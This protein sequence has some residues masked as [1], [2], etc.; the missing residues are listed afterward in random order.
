MSCI[1]RE[2]AL[3]NVRIVDAETDAAGI[4]F[5]C[6]EKITRIA[7]GDF[8]VRESAEGL[9]K[10]SGERA[11]IDFVDGGKATLMPSFI[12]MH[13]HFRYPGQGQKE[14]LQSALSAGAAG[15]F[16][17]AVLM[18]NTRPPVSDENTAMRIQREAET[19]GLM[20]VFQAVSITAEQRGE[21][22]A[23]LDALEQTLVISEDGLD[24][25]D[26]ALMLDAMKIAAKKNIIV[27]C[28]CEDARL[29]LE[30]NKHRA[31][32]LEI[33]K[34]HGGLF[35]SPSKESRAD[36]FCAQEEIKKANDFFTLAENIATERNIALAETADCR[37]HICHAST[38]RAV[39]SV[40]R[41]KQRNL[42]SISC[43][44]TPHHIALCQEGSGGLFAFV[45]PPL[46]P[47]SCRE[48]LI[49]ALALGVIDVIATD[50]A[51]HT[52]ADKENGAAGFPGLE[53]AFA[54]CNTHL[55]QSGVLTLQKISAL[56]SANPAR[57]LGIQKSRGKIQAGMDADFVLVD[58]KETWT[59][60]AKS[61][62]TKGAYSPFDG[63]QLAGKIK[64]VY[65]K[66]IR[67]FPF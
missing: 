24:V 13:A 61:F 7:V 55:V 20:D 65:K 46:R 67:V 32:A 31:R 8:S 52:A 43:E 50:H 34:K 40:A 1:M 28:H 6:G 59:V 33:L 27:A 4:V 39:D 47:R 26:A 57:L 58:P 56:M 45:N 66:G 35:A 63:I 17:T 23:A 41:A 12:D 62:Y 48:A 44:V 42:C 49:N 53:T 22:I 30:A 54:V 16:G 36:F 3:Y 11:G 37:L 60:D 25:R 21:S 14:T 19:F 51:P 64:A 29:S 9:L 2:S 5:F 15:G 38:A 18:P 10:N